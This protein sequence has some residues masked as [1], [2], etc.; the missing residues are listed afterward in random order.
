MV[1]EDTRLVADVELRTTGANVHAVRGA[2][3]LYRLQVQI[4]NLHANDGEVPR[5][6]L[7]QMER[8]LRRFVVTGE[9]DRHWH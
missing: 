2:L 7:E 9:L 4:V 3:Q 8:S 1:T 6:Q 5:R